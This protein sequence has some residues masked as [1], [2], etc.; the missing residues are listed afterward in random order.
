MNHSLV[1]TYDRDSAE[2][3]GVGVTIDGTP[4]VT[5]VQLAV[6]PS[7]SPPTRRLRRRR[8]R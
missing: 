1:E 2:L 4:A 5:G 3:V 7:A 6:T 8:R